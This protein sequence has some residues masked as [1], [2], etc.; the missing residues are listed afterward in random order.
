VAEFPTRLRSA[1]LSATL[2][3]EGIVQIQAY[4]MGVKKTITLDDY[5]PFRKYSTGGLSTTLAYA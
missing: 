4:V 5:L 1:F 2:P 3:A